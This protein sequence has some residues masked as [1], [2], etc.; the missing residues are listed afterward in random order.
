MKNFDKKRVIFL[1]IE[2]LLVSTSMSIRKGEDIS[3]SFASMIIAVT[4]LKLICNYAIK[5]GA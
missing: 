5:I 3:S 1:L 2:Y 4:I